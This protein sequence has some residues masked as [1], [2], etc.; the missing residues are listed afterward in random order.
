MRAVGMV[1]IAA[2]ALSGCGDDDGAAPPDGGMMRVDT[3]MTGEDAAPGDDAGAGDDGGAGEDA[4]PPVDAGPNV[5]LTN[6]PMS[7]AMA[8]YT[9][10]DPANGGHYAAARLTP[11]RFPFTVTS[12]FYALVHKPGTCNADLVHEVLVFTSSETT[13]PGTP[14]GVTVPVPAP[15]TPTAAGTARRVETMLDTPV[16]V[17]AGEELFVAVQ[18]ARGAEPLCLEECLD[19]GEADRNWWSAAAMPPFPWATLASYGNDGT[20]TV[21]V[22]GH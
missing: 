14:G 18:M 2:V 9:F 8:G 7:C 3:G 5:R 15:A 22:I 10:A 19:P 17:N 21:G 11:P 1:V 4:G 16:V 12:V 13:P 6:A 20:V